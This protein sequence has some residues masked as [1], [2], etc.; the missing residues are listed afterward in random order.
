MDSQ[1]IAA[2]DNTAVQ[3]ADLH[4]RLVPTGIYQLIE[5]FFIQ[6]KKCADIG[7]GI[8]RDSAWL[9]KNGFEIVGVDASEG[10]L[11]EAKNRYPTVDFIKD[12]LPLLAKFSDLAFSNI[13]C[14]AVIMHLEANQIGS[15]VTNL[16]RIA[17]ESGV[18]ILSFRGTQSDD[19]REGGKLYIPID[20]QNLIALFAE[21]GAIL[22]HQEG[23]FEHGRGLEWISL[24]FRKSPIRVA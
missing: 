12:S 21:A 20:P 19:C 4:A 18:V 22:L 11:Q 14:S 15:A 13:L 9:S 5:Q 2:Y 6:G 24:V 17:T 7:C 23:V 8:G 1:T 16:M 3:V 10:M